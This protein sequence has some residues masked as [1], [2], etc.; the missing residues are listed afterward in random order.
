MLHEPAAVTVI[1]SPLTEQVS[2]V[3]DA[4]ETVRAELAVALAGK[5]RGVPE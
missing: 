3:S 2:G 4:S 1:E 5:V